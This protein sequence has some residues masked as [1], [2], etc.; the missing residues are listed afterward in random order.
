VI[1]SFCVVALNTLI[2]PFV[3]AW[4]GKN[5]LMSTTVVVVLSANFFLSNMR[6]TN[7]SFV[8]ASGLFR[9]DKLR[10]LIESVV[11]LV[12]SIILVINFG[13]IGIF[14]GAIISNFT[15]VFWREGYLIHKNEFHQKP[16]RYYI[17]VFAF[18][19]VTI[20]LSL[21][22][23]YLC[24]FFPSTW[25]YVILKF[26]LCGVIPPIILITLTFWTKEFK[27]FHNLIKGVV[28]KKFKR[29]GINKT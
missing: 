22:M 18:I 10:P 6:L 28:L 3:E 9:K 17:Y 13:I 7:T 25:R 20:A 5:M 4:L 2:N 27:Y 12:A 19:I 8:M 23:Y 29:K 24:G 15:V 11:H 16:Y 14:I 26:V 1:V 21:L